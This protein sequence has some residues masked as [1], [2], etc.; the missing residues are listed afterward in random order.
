MKLHCRPL[1]RPVCFLLSLCVVAGVLLPAGGASAAGSIRLSRYF[2]AP[3]DTVTVYGHGFTAQDVAVVS[4]SLYVQSGW[5]RVVATAGVDAA[6]AFT[7]TFTVP[8]ATAQGTYPVS[9]KDFHGHV[10]TQDLSVRPVA[11]FQPGAGTPLVNVVANHSFFARGTG[12]RAGEQV[13]LTASFPL[14]NGNVY[15]V[16]Q[17]ARVD[18]SGR[19]GELQIALPRG[20]RTGDLIM[21]ATGLQSG[22]KAS[23]RLRVGYRPSVSL[24]S[25]SVRPGTSVAVNGRDF[26]PGSAVRVSVTIPRTGTTTET[27]TRTVTANDSGNFATSLALPSNVRPGT[28]PITATDTVGGFQ[29]SARVTVSVHARLIVQPASVVAGQAASV[30]GSAFPSGIGVNVG[31]SFPL[32]QGGARAVSI[33]VRTGAAGDFSAL[34]TVPADAATSTVT[35]VAQGVNS[36]ATASLH[37]Q[38]APTPTVPPTATPT[39]TPT[40]TPRPV[41]KGRFAFKSVSL[42][43]HTVRAGTWDRLV[44]QSGLKTRQSVWVKVYF[45]NARPLAYYELSNRKGRWSKTFRIPSSAKSRYTN[46]GHVTIQLWHGKHTIR[47]FL[48]FTIV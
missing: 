18:P 48:D 47:Y 45:P 44:V 2:A 5:Q 35:I 7:A 38:Q 6:G 16:S 25:Q 10:A 19:F 20:A 46:V 21:T 30:V 39:A 34:L 32:A 29:A 12:F 41:H 17:T 8:T 42:W 1:L 37:V 4:T 40:P 33:T 24:A 13:R 9:A 26:V 43:Y 15:V 31:A 28:Y 22:R 14:Y 23:A 3:S 11:S 27:L 36:R